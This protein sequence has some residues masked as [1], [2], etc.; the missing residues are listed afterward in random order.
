MRPHHNRPHPHRRHQRARNRTLLSQGESISLPFRRPLPP[1]LSYT[2]NAIQTDASRLSLPSK[3]SS[4]TIL[5]DL[6]DISGADYIG[7]DSTAS[8]LGTAPTYTI[9]LLTACG[10]FPADGSIQCAPASLGFSFSP[11][12]TLKLDSTILSGTYSEDLLKSLSAYSK[13]SRWLAM[14]YIASS[15]FLLFTII[16]NIF[17]A[18]GAAFAAFVSTVLL[19]SASVASAVTFGKVNS[20]FN[21]DLESRAKVS[22]QLGRTPV[23]LSFVAFIFALSVTIS[24]VM[25]SRLQAA[26]RRRGPLAV[27]A[28]GKDSFL[29]GGGPGRGGDPYAAPSPGLPGKG[30]KKGGLLANVTSILPGQRHKYVQIGEGQPALVRTDVEGRTRSVQGDGGQH[31]EDWGARDEYS[32]AAAPRSRSVSPG[33]DTR[34]L[35]MGDSVPL[36]SLGGGGAGNKPSRNM[37]S[38][39]EPYSSLPGGK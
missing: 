19:F 23:A 29:G 27:G 37:D 34:P 15:V 22:S 32:H 12:S 21:A 7:P 11:G 39:Y 28:G 17:S 3:L 36:V 8:S 24:L 20:A 30:G 18:G 33:G 35:K 1:S 31:D 38:A 25:Y 16:V 26:Q 9:H 2:N 4:S 13:L 14:A 6:S 10:H 5:K